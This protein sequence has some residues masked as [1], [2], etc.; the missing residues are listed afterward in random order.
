M[1][2][3]EREERARRLFIALEP[4]PP[5]PATHASLHNTPPPSHHHHHQGTVFIARVRSL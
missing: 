4:S 2:E 3:R 1:G 5:T